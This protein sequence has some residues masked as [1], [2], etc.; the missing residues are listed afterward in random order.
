MRDWTLEQSIPGFREHLK[1]VLLARARERDPG[2][3]LTQFDIAYGE[4]TNSALKK[5][6][7]GALMGI[8]KIV[9]KRKGR[10]KIDNCGI[11]QVYHNPTPEMEQQ[12]MLNEMD[13][14]ETRGLSHRA[15]INLNMRNEI[16]RVMK[17]KLLGW[18]AR[19]I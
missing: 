7:Y 1:E 19:R 12:A 17:R 6:L 8:L 16:N 13:L 2:V 11:A 15:A 3:S 9:K 4:L 14:D 5:V 10:V 18:K